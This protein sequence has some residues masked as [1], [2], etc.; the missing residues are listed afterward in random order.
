MEALY[1]Q[2]PNG[3]VRNIFDF[4]RP[5]L[6]KVDPGGCFSC[7]QMPLKPRCNDLSNSYAPTLSAPST[8]KI[9]IPIVDVHQIR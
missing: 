7:G 4:S 3:F 8:A 1:Y 6:S 2:Q 9:A 5:T